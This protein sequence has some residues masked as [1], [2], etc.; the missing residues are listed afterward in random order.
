MVI[1]VAGEIDFYTAPRLRELCIE[2]IN[3]RNY[4][5]IIDLGQCDSWIRRDW[6][7]W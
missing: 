3:N 6:E 2:L 4:N 5:L 7:S 1:E